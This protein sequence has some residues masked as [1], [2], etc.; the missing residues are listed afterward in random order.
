MNSWVTA[1][2]DISRGAYQLLV[3]SR[4]CLLFQKPINV[5]IRKGAGRRFQ[6]ALPLLGSISMGPENDI[7]RWVIE[8][9]LH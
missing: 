3:S 4:A 2:D 1:I 7:H 5:L 9:M 6:T 8:D